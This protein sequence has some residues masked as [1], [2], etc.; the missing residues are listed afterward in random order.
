MFNSTFYPTPSHL[1]SKVAWLFN[2]LD[3]G[4]V[5]DPSAGAG[6][7]LDAVKK[8]YEHEYNRRPPKLYAVEIDANLRAILYDKGYPIAGEDFLT[9]WPVVQFTHILMNPPFDRAE[10]HLLHAWEILVKGKI[11]CIYPKAA[12]EGKNAKERLVLTVIEDNGGKVEDIGQPFAKA[13]RPTDVECVII[14]LEKKPD[15]T[16]SGLDF[17]TKND[18][19]DPDLADADQE[20]TINSFVGDL[21]AAYNAT[22]EDTAAYNLARTRIKRHAAPFLSYYDG[23]K[24]PIEAADAVDDPFERYNLFVELITASAWSAVFH[25]PSFRRILTKRAREMFDEFLAKQKRV[26]FNEHNIKAL[27]AALVARQDDLLN[28]AIGDAFDTMTRWHD[29][30]REHVEGWKS[31][32]AYKVKR[33]CIIPNGV[34]LSWGKFEVEYSGRRREFD[35]IDRA[36]C[37][38]TGRNFDTITTIVKAIEQRPMFQEATSTFFDLRWFKKGTVHLTWLDEQVRRDFNIAAARGRG[39]LPPAKGAFS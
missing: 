19:P 34:R 18:R 1:A 11:A 33:R 28:A 5:L 36:L 4:Y 29:E 13:E 15:P 30:N 26:D 39:W 38:V 6:A 37:V 20:M 3:R 7:L 17:A 32:E 22:I 16:L 31:N 9:Y 21:L 35:D 23:S 10:D 27:F 24:N 8:R 14:T 2:D 12:L 25:H